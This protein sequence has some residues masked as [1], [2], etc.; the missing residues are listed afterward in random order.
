MKEFKVGD[1]FVYCPNNRVCLFKITK[2]GGWDDKKKC[3][4]IE[5]KRYT[6]VGNTGSYNDD[7][8]ETGSAVIMIDEHNNK[9]YVQIDHWFTHKYCVRH[10]VY[11]E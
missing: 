6:Y 8:F 10:I 2:I 3:K 7:E 11:C 1:G 4:T 9:E 5:Y